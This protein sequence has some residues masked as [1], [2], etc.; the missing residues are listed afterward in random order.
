MNACI[1]D[2]QSRTG[3]TC[4]GVTWVESGQDQQWC[5]YKPATATFNNINNPAIQSAQ[6]ICYPTVPVCPS[7]NQTLYQS[8]AKFKIAQ[9]SSRAGLTDNPGIDGSVFRLDCNIDY[10]GNDNGLFMVNGMQ[11]CMDTCDQRGS[12]CPGAVY[13]PSYAANPN[14]NPYSCFIKN[15]VPASIAKKQTFECDSFIRLNTGSSLATGTEVTCTANNNAVYRTADG[16]Q[17]Q[18]VCGTDVS[19][20]SL[21]PI[22]TPL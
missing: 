14:S 20:P 4:Q 8:K 6:R 11:G 18:L 17:F 16:S 12:T 5:Y 13:V 2:C 9:G 15:S 10:P 7:G 3:G 1:L 22:N 21:N 19:G